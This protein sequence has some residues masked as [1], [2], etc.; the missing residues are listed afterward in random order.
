MAE[1]EE[2]KSKLTEMKIGLFV[3]FFGAVLAIA[4][5]GGGKYDGDQ[6][7]SAAE[8]TKA[9]AWYQSKSIKNTSLEAQKDLL[10]ALIKSGAINKDYSAGVDSFIKKLEDKS[11]KYKNEM[12]EI[13]EGS[14][15]VG[16]ENWAQD[17]NGEMGVIIG[18]QEWE[19]KTAYLDMVGDWFNYTNLFL[20]LCLVFGA[21]CLVIQN[22]KTQKIFFIAMVVLGI[23]GTI[24]CIYS[25]YLGWLT[26]YN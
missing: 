14:D 21:I 10:V 7:M 23:I 2:E 13:L 25:F 19:E 16:K 18:A 24:L 8:A 11:Q 9:Y 6:N 3:A 12:R 26:P 22:E 4:G 17:K 5:I 20:N 1:Q 15:K